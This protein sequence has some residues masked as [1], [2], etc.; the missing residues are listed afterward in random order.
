M[1]EC[2]MSSMC[3]PREKCI[4]TPGSYTCQYTCS[5]GFRNSPVGTSC[6]GLCILHSV[7]YNICNFC[8]IILIRVA[9][10]T[11]ILN[12]MYFQVLEVSIMFPGWA[13]VVICQKNKLDIH[14]LHE[15]FQSCVFIMNLNKWRPSKKKGLTLESKEVII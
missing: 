10:F 5:R 4:N 12:H 9:Y 3:G 8:W 11:V 15:T 2:S 7:M 6:E 14:C 1:D 13:F